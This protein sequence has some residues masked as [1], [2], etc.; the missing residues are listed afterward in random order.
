M[1]EFVVDE[2]DPRVE[3][4]DWLEGMYEDQTHLDDDDDPELHDEHW[5]DWEEDDGEWDNDVQRHATPAGFHSLDTLGQAPLQQKINDALRTLSDQLASG[6]TTHFHQVLTFYAKLYR[7]S[8]TNAILIMLA[9]PDADVVAGYR[10]WQTLGRQVK[11]GAKAAQIWCPISRKLTDE[12]TGEE[13]YRVVGFRTGYVYSDK[14]L[15]DIETNPLPTGRPQLPD[16]RIELLAYLRQK[17]LDSGVSIREVDHLP[18]AH[19]LYNRV[20]HQITLVR[21]KDSTNQTLIL[22]HEWAH[23]LFHQDASDWSKGQ[24]EFEAET[25]T[26]VMASILGLPSPYASDYL[27]TFGATPEQLASSF[28]R[29]HRLVGEMSKHLGLGRTAGE[30]DA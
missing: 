4:D 28:G 3:L 30:D 17:V 25:T 9:K 29:I 10:R 18:Q 14:D 16:D 15:V 2:S 21:G 27:L 5:F 12:V 1:A 26:M 19:G 20:D 23:S 8:F 24:K 22:L 6:Y 13:A 7:Y 11:R